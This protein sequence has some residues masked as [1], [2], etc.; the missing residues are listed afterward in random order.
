[1]IEIYRLLITDVTRYGSLFCVAGW[2]LNSNRMIRPEP[3]GAT[4]QNESSRFWHNDSAGPGK[5]F[6]VGNIVEVAAST[7]PPDFPFP[8][9]TED[10]IYFHHK[11]NN[12]IK[13]LPHTEI[14]YAVR[15]GIKTSLNDIFGGN[16]QVTS[17]GKIYVDA[18][19]QTCSLDS[20]TITPG[21]ISFYSKPNEKNQEKLRARISE[22][23]NTYNFSVPADAAL[24]LF[25]GGGVDALAH[26]AN[27]S[28]KIHVRLGLSRPYV[29]IPNTCYVQINGLYFL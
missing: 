14:V 18:N 26:A 25:S 23:T 24:S 27:S 1:M 5:F 28:Q 6:D 7:P 8:H 21:Q 19:T 12:L 9:A 29:K 15:T 13:K 20:I 2:D 4:A 11:S 22:K 17:T 16:F 3:Q 10:R